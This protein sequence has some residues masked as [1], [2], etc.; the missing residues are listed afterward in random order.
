MHNRKLSFSCSL[1]SQGI[2]TVNSSTIDIADF[3]KTPDSL[4]DG[5]P[6]G[7][8]SPPGIEPYH[9]LVRQMYKQLHCHLTPLNTNHSYKLRQNSHW[10]CIC[11]L[12]A[13]AFLHSTFFHFY[14]HFSKLNGILQC[15]IH[16]VFLVYSYTKPKWWEIYI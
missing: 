16:W 6:Q 1:I 13:R 5:T 12:S 10:V 3:F 15:E 4:P 2:T 14:G 7:F 9:L 11:F 8:M